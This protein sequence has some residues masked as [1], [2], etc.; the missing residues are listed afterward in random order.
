MTQ[1]AKHTNV[2]IEKTDAEIRGLMSRYGATAFVSGW[3]GNRALVQFEFRKRTV[4]IQMTLPE[5]SS[6]AF[7]NGRTIAEECEPQI[8]VWI[9]NGTMPRLLAA[10]EGA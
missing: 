7:T 2:P 8:R 1:F 9:E 3:N 4:Q 6:K 10:P 5:Q